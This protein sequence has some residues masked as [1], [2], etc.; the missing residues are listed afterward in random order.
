MENGEVHEGGG[1][2]GS[3]EGHSSRQYCFDQVV[4]H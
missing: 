2:G 3:I 1:T 4:A